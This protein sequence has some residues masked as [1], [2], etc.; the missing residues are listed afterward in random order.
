MKNKTVITFLVFSL[1]ACPLF[2]FSTQSEKSRTRFYYAFEEQIEINPVENK[3]F[4]KKKSIQAKPEFEKLIKN[5]LGNIKI[6]WQGNDMC[7]IELTDLKDKEEKMN[8]L[9][10]EEGIFSVRDVYKTNGG[11]ELGFSDEILVRYKEG[12]DDTVKENIIR[13]F[14]LKES[15]K[16]KIYEAY[17]LSKSEDIIEIANKMYESGMFEFAYPSIMC[18]VEFAS[19]IIPN[20]TYFQYQIT[21]H[22]TGQTINDGHSGTPGADIDAPDA[23]DITTGNSNI[24][25]AVI[26]GGVTEDHPDLPNTRQ[27]RLKGSNFSYGDPDDPSP[28]E[29]GDEH[30]NACAGVIGATMNNYQGIAGIAPNCKIMPVRINVHTTTTGMANAIVFAVDSGANILSNSWT[31]KDP[32]PNL[33]PVIISAIQYAINKGRIVVF[34]AGNTAAH[35]SGNDGYVAFPANAS[36]NSLLSV[37]ASDRYDYQSDYS[38]TSPLVDIVAPSNRAISASIPGENGEMWTMDIP[39]IA[40][41]NPSDSGEILPDSGTDYLAYTGRFGGTSHACPVVAG[42][43]ALILSRNPYLTPQEVYYILTGTADKIGNYSYINGRCDETGF[44]RVNAHAAVQAAC[45]TTNFTGQTVT[46]DTTIADCE[47]NVQNITVTNNAKLT[48]DALMETVISSEFEV[49]LGSELE[50]K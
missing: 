48:L 5:L 46:S 14:H 11:L 13:K 4:V 37:G 28:T 47:I 18:E 1:F 41:Y 7:K 36:I 8:K 34:S 39:G 27:I 29:S 16:T 17:N 26:D 33:H 15:Q 31:Y 6:E 45:T 42:V 50:I 10:S 21:C 23:W 2:P 35:A 38:P 43:A 49:L 20:D 40:G 30:G 3:L 25:V 9:L 19:G 22:N 12:I 44:G 32:N 24:I